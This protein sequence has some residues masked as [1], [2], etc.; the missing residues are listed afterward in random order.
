MTAPDGTPRRSVP[1]LVGSHRTAPAR[2]LPDRREDVLLEELDFCSWL[3]ALDANTAQAAAVVPRRPGS[4][5][6]VA[7]P[8]GGASRSG[9]ASSTRRTGS[10]CG[11][12]VTERV[13]RSDFATGR[14]SGCAGPEAGRSPC[15]A[16]AEPRAGGTCWTT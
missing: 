8:V 3:L 12:V 16:H 14:A 13:V 2:L 11:W 6:D 1:G 9:L 10:G 4:Q 7:E 5:V 15:P